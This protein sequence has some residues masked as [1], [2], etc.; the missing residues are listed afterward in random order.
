MSRVTRSCQHEKPP[1]AAGSASAIA[2]TPKA[3]PLYGVVDGDV[4]AIG[5]RCIEGRRS[6]LAGPWLGPER[7][8]NRWAVSVTALG[9]VLAAAVLHTAWNLLA[10]AGDDSLS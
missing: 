4:A 2:A 3:I 10:K 6:R 1:A 5:G 8:T 7:D 9:L